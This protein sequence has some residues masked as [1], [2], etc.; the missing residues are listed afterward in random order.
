MIYIQNSPGLYIRQKPQEHTL[1]P[2][3]EALTDTWGNPEEGQWDYEYPSEAEFLDTVYQ[4]CRR[5]V[6]TSLHLKIQLAKQESLRMTAK[7]GH[8]M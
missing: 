6:G 4:V 1:D 7:L 8:T 5:W 3:E 2:L